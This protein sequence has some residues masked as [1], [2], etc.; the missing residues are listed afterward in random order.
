MLLAHCRVTAVLAIAALR[1]VAGE[2]YPPGRDQEDDQELALGIAI[3][4]A[5]RNPRD[6]D[7]RKAPGD[8]GHP[9]I[10]KRKARKPSAEH[11]RYSSPKRR[12]LNRGI[13]HGR[14]MRG[15]IAARAAQTIRPSF[16]PSVS[17][18][19]LLSSRRSVRA[20]TWAKPTIVCPRSSAAASA[21]W[22]VSSE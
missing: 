11:D 4:N 15:Q 17:G 13:K 6:R 19:Q 9:G 3:A 21:S 18:V 12:E 16:S 2:P 22:S 14:S 1:D 7:E 10:A 20:P 8:I 5:Q